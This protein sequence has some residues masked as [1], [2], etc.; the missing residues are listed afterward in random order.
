M[1][2]DIAK[3]PLE[4][5]INRVCGTI[6]LILDKISHVGYFVYEAGQNDGFK[7]ALI[8]LE[9]SVSIVA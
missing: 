6:T 8:V 1:S 4:G 5:C 9:M 2:C 7:Q 3:L